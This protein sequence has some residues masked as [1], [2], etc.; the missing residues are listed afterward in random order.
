MKVQ[1]PVSRMTSGIP[2]FRTR[3]RHERFGMQFAAVAKG[4]RPDGSRD[5]QCDRATGILLR[6]VHGLK[7][8][9]GDQSVLSV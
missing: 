2:G 4:R 8:Q 7:Q 1:R 3:I 6:P 5:V 9:C